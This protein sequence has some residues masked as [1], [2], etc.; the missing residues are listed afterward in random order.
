MAEC[1]KRWALVRGSHL[2][3]AWKGASSSRLLSSPSASCPPSSPLPAPSPS[4]VLLPGAGYGRKSPK[5]VSQ[6]KSFLLKV[7]GIWCFV[8]VRKTKPYREDQKG[9]LN[10]T[11]CCFW[12]SPGLRFSMNTD[13]NAALTRLR[14]HLCPW[15]CVSQGDS[16]DITSVQPWTVC[17]SWQ[18]ESP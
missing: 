8:P 10:T 17:M 3:V 18:L 5:T 12:D 7:E 15:A 4:T 11:C 6:D 2:G 14:E 16:K 9:S 1:Y 13:S